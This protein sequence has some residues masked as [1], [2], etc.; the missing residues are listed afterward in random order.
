MTNRELLELAAKAAGY[1]ASYA[2]EA[3]N[4]PGMMAR[5]GLEEALYVEEIGEWWNPLEDDGDALRLAVKL[6]LNICNEQTSSGAAYCMDGEMDHAYPQVKSGKNEG[7]VIP[8]DYEATR[9][10][11]VLAA[12]EMAQAIA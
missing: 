4:L 11:I 12:V 5:Y 9:R 2:S 1:T 3:T 7:D 6:Q 8:D 10:A